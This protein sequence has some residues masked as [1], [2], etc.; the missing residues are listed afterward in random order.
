M[1]Q[2]QYSF[3]WAFQTSSRKTVF[4]NVCFRPP[5]IERIYSKSCGTWGQNL[6]RHFAISGGFPATI[7]T[8]NW[9][10]NNQEVRHQPF[11]K[12]Y[13]LL[14]LWKLNPRVSW[15]VINNTPF[16]HG[17][18]DNN[19][20]SWNSYLKRN[21]G[22]L[23]IH[24]ETFLCVSHYLQL[25]RVPICIWCGSCINLFQR[26]QM[27]YQKHNRPKARS[28]GKLRPLA[29]CNVSLFDPSHGFV[30]VNLHKPVQQT[31]L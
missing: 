31:Q 10:N 29:C 17:A 6:T 5:H 1:C 4:S 7:P 23:H 20:P 15:F 2:G 25:H 18:V 13:R 21:S 12:P 30:E 9:L 24:E 26:Q 3:T 8:K 27:G 14:G 16:H 19:D 11:W 28:E 22:I